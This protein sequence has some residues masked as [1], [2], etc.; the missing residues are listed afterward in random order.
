MKTPVDVVLEQVK[1][2]FALREYQKED[3]N[4]LAVLDKTGLWISLGL[5]KTVI[6]FCMGCYKLIKAEFKKCY[7]LC[8]ASLVTQWVDFIAPTK[9]S[10]VAYKG[11]P[12][13]RE[14]LDITANFVVMSYEMFRQDYD[15][16]KSSEAYYILDE[17][18]VFCNTSNI[19]YKM[20]AGG[21]VRKEKKIPGKLKPEIIKRSFEPI[22]KGCCMLTA[23]PLN[24]IEDS[25]GLINLKTPGVY[26]SVYQFERIH[27]SS[28]NYFN[29]PE[30]Y[31]N[32]DLLKDNLMLNSSRRLVS[33]H[34]DLPPITYNTILYDLS[35]EH[36][37]LYEKLID[38]R[39]LEFDGEVLIDAVSAMALYQACQKIIIC[40][41]GG[42]LKIAPAI[43]ELLDL[44]IDRAQQFII[45]SNYVNT[46]K[47]FM[48]K[49][50]IGGVFGGVGN[51]DKTISDFKEGKLKGLAINTR[52]GGSGLNLQNNNT[53]MFAELPITPR[54]F[55]QAVGRCHRSGQEQKVVVNIFVARS[56]I[57]ETLAARIIQK[58][59]MTQQV[60][61]ESDLM[62]LN[63]TQNVKTKKQLLAELKGQVQK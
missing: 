11:S 43:F 48:E 17:A 62:E 32:L 26:S 59:E 49:Y 8:P 37:R 19:V 5:G 31:Q 55:R 45:F 57:Q 7:V 47:K 41:E 36:Q 40:P 60:M 18:T 25:F 29:Q 15:R 16:L 35:P 58:D 39:M 42:G 14:N 56:T 22:L 38:E 6:A 10:V 23:T 12:K 24:R 61:G 51:R 4:K 21:E 30:T 46:N 27:I 34:I 52:A 20:L 44:H 54:D 9:A 28:K 33:D 1:L 63:L 50:S 2:P 13:Q 53:I 3:I